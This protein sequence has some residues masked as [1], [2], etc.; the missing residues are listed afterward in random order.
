[1]A[2]AGTAPAG[3][4][5]RLPQTQVAAAV[6]STQILDLA[7]LVILTL[8]S[9]WLKF[10]NKLSIVCYSKL[11]RSLID[12]H[13]ITR[14]VSPAL[15]PPCRISLMAYCYELPYLHFH[16]TCGAQSLIGSLYMLQSTQ[17]VAV[18]PPSK[19]KST[20]V[21][22]CDIPYLLRGWIYPY[23][24]LRAVAWNSLLAHNLQS[25]MS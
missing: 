13:S 21:Q 15:Q 23:T 25:A 22:L 11:W 4:G 8:L 17:L 1:M 6:A 20:R 5:A 14:G 12:S 24:S 18:S 2:M 3:D 16:L 19:S 9:F 10:S 7:I